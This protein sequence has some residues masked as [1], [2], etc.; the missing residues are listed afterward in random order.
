[1]H[2]VYSTTYPTRISSIFDLGT[3]FQESR[4][5]RRPI[6]LVSSV[7]SI[8]KYKRP[9]PATHMY[10]KFQDIFAAP[11]VVAL[12]LKRQPAVASPSGYVNSK[13]TAISHIVTVE[14]T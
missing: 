1:M 6:C 5:P 7:C 2:H 9:G 11:E 14:H 3:P 4:V 13:K 10:L 8:F 12:Q